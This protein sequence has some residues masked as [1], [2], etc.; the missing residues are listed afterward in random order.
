MKTYRGV[1]VYLHTLNSA[2][3]GASR[4]GRFTPGETAPGAHWRGGWVS[5]RT[6]LDAVAKKKSHLCSRWEL[7]SGRPARSLV[8]TLNETSQYRHLLHQ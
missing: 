3:D 7:N 1:E 2:L 8:S 4:P 5:P 6:G